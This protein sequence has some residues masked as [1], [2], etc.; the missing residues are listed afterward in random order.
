MGLGCLG[1]HL[2]RS[3]SS[4]PAPRWR[5]NGWEEGKAVL[6]VSITGWEEGKAVLIVSITCR[7]NSGLMYKSRDYH[8]PAKQPWARA[9]SPRAADPVK[10]RQSKSPVDSRFVH[11]TS[12]IIHRPRVTREKKPREPRKPIQYTH[13]V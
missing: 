10:R 13:T 12:Y 4:R 8:D 1:L 11:H 7:A 3:S 2:D 9:A 6:L 5:H